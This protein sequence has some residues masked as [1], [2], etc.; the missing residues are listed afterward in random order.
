MELRAKNGNRAEPIDDEDKENESEN[1]GTDGVSSR[2][3]KMGDGAEPESIED[4][5]NVGKS[6][7]T[8][9]QK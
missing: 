1:V 3:I 4:K 9:E 8:I 5:Y 6:R 7:E 2:F